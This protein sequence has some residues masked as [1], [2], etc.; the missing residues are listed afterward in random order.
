M[1]QHSIRKSSEATVERLPSIYGKVSGHV[2]TRSARPAKLLLCG[3]DKV[4]NQQDIGCQTA[5]FGEWIGPPL[6]IIELDASKT[7]QGTDDSHEGA[8]CNETRGN[9]VA[10]L[11]TGLINTASSKYKYE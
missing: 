3:A 4:E 8:T 11:A 2:R 7:E 1:A 5:E 9:E 10:F 6:G